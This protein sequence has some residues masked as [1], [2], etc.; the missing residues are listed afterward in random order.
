M[1]EIEFTASA[2][3][4]LRQ[5]KKGEQ[6]LILDR[7]ESQ[8]KAEPLVE[9][10]NRKPLRPNDLSQWEVRIE[11]FRVFYDVNAE[12][13]IVTIKALGHKEHNTLIIRGQEFEL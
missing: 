12:E 7:I 4:D 8:L 10:R 1:F 11:K 9:T 2:L 3:E 6:S 13:N 5:Y